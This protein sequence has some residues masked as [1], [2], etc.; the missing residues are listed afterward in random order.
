LLRLRRLVDRHHIK[1]LLQLALQALYKLAKSLQI[2][3]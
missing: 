3:L 1:V 2:L